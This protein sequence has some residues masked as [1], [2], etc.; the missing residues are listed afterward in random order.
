[1]RIGLISIAL[2]FIFGCS[3]P[4]Q[5]I[6]ESAI[7]IGMRQE[8][9]IVKDLANMAK[10]FAVDKAV[11]E[12]RLAASDVD[13]DKAQEIVQNLA[14]NFTKIAWLESQ[15][16]RARSVLG[17]AQQYIWSQQ[18]FLDILWRELKQAKEI[19]DAK[20]PASIA[21]PPEIVRLLSD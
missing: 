5:R 15:H 21:L 11:S 19:S 17:L 8:S 1:M 16:E 3:T 9:S 2:L 18:G 4:T 12:A 13:A 7:Q 20:N 6:A 14:N 10:Q